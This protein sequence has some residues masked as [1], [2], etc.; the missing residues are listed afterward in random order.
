MHVR[1]QGGHIFFSLFQS[2]KGIIPGSSVPIVFDQKWYFSLGTFK[3]FYLPLFFSHSTVMCLGV[4]SFG[5]ILLG[6]AEFLK[7]ENRHF[8]YIWE[9]CSHYFLCFLFHPSIFSCSGILITYLFIPWYYPKVTDHFCYFRLKTCHC[10]GFKFTDP[11][12]CCLQSVV[13]PIQYSQCVFTNFG[14]TCSLQYFHLVFFYNFHCSIN[15][16]HLFNH[17]GHILCLALEHIYK[18][19]FKV[20]FC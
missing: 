20:L 9:I 6:F 16:T 13:K 8:C 5:L 14:F 12:L 15:I 11:F 7:P 1:F 19:C 4:V 18:S 3:I 2:F 10:S 17:Y